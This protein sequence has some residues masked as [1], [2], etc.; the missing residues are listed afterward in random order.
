MEAGVVLSGAGSVVKA[1]GGCAEIEE[2]QNAK[3]RPA[4][5]TYRRKDMTR[6]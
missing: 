1:A 2:Q 4:A 3:K 5:E 6:L